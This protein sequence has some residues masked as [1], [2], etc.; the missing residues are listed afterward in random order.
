MYSSQALWNAVSN[1]LVRDR[2]LAERDEGE[3]GAQAPQDQA[4]G[5]MTAA[6]AELSYVLYTYYHLI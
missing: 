2:S 6:A 3:L 4:S 5:L 1:P